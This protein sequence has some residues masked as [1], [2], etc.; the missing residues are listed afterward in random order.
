MKKRKSQR[1]VHTT[2]PQNMN[3]INLTLTVDVPDLRVL[4]TWP[5][6]TVDAFLRG[7][8]QVV[9]AKRMVHDLRL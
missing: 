3:A 7:I 8:A 5:P 1:P 9:S 6:A 4:A 2:L